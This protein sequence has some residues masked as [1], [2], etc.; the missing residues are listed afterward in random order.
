MAKK[1]SKSASG[2]RRQISLKKIVAE[3]DKVLAELEK[4]ATKERSIEGV[5]NVTRARLSLKAARD[6]VQSACVPNFDFPEA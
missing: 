4:P 6:A 1:T 5:Y 3:I 2:R